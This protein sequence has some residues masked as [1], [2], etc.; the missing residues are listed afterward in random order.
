MCKVCVYAICKNEEKLIQ[1]WIDSVSDADYIVVLDTGSTDST[2]DIL[3]KNTRVIWKQTTIN[4]WRFDTARNTALSICPKDTDIF[5]CLDIDEKISNGWCD[6]LKS[7]WTDTTKIAIFNYN[8]I[9]NDNCQEYY[10]KEKAHNIEF[11]WKYQI[12]EVLTNTESDDI[13]IVVD[14]EDQILNLPEITITHGRNIQHSD[15]YLKL[16][17]ES[18][19]EY[20][21]ARCITMYARELLSLGDKESAIIQFNKQI[22]QETTDANKLYKLYSLNSLANIYKYD[23]PCYAIY[24]SSESILIDSKYLEPYLTMAESYCNINQPKIALEII[25]SAQEQCIFRKS[26]IESMLSWE[27]ALPTLKVICLSKLSLKDEAFK[28]ISNIH[29]VEVK[30]KLTKFIE[31]N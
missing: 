18:V 1:Q 21:N 2:T 12:H 27:I 17:E 10:T 7:N 9:S 24:Y 25:N 31:N 26:W 16:L 23:F 15:N 11:K 6:I 28:V 5:V 19:K 3:N 8:L 13:A 29:D 14:S 22:V 20:N 4:P 30:D